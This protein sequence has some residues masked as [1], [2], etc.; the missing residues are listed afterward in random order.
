MSGNINDEKVTDRERLTFS[1]LTNLEWQF[2]NI[3]KKVK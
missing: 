3:K 1:E 2:V